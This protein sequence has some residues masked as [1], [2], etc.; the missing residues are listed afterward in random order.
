MAEK[1]KHRFSN[2][3]KVL[4]LILAIISLIPY[5]CLPKILQD[6]KNILESVNPL[7]RLHDWIVSMDETE[8][9]EKLQPGDHIYCYRKKFYSHH[10]IYNGDGRVW[11]YDGKTMADAQIK[12]STLAEFSNG[13]RI[14]K[15]NYTADFTPDEILERAASRKFEA[16]Y[17][18]IA[19][20]CMHFAFWCRLSSG[21]STEATER[22]FDLLLNEGIG[23]A[24][25]ESV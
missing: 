5:K 17:D 24:L 16:C 22:V 11:E 13:D 21:E 12:L 1:N 9:K 7:K 10:G 6:L 18:I 14:N 8:A 4:L 19:N 25:T 2:N 15:L 20:N 23:K 3:S